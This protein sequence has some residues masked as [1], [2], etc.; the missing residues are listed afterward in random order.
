MEPVAKMKKG[1]NAA[2]ALFGFFLFFSCRGQ[3]SPNDTL[4][5]QEIAPIPQSVIVV[6]QP[7]TEYEPV[8][9]NFRIIEVSEVNG[10][11]RFFM[12]RMGAERTG[13]Q[14]GVTGEIG[15]DAAFQRVI[16][17]FKI[18]ELLGDFFRCEITELT[19][20]IGTNTYAR[21]QIGERVR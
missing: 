3:P 10:V 6:R 9:S 20:R 17:S 19:H 4:V 8:Y 15:E 2:V 5:L 12:V 21:V 1:H 18:I 16:G 11:Q 14:V 13:I 7:V